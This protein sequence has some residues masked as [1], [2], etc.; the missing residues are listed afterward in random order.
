MRSYP[1]SPEYPI[2]D[3][4]R[5]ATGPHEV[6]T[7]EKLRAMPGYGTIHEEARTPRL[8]WWDRLRERL[9]FHQHR[10]VRVTWTQDETSWATDPNAWDYCSCGARRHAFTNHWQEP[11]HARR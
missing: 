6:P 5:G 10:S 3:T 2:P 11:S 1:L 8:S 4:P 9:G 7:L